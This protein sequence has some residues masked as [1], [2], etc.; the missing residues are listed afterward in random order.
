VTRDEITAVLQ[1]HFRPEFLNR[2][3]EIVTFHPLERE[4]LRL[5]VEIQ[6]QRVAELLAERG[7]DLDVTPE[8]VDYLTEV[9]YNPDFGARPLKR[10][11]QRELQ[12]PLALAILSGKFLEGELIRVERGQEGLEFSPVLNSAEMETPVV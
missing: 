10:A 2:I 8:A 1:A 11:I 7:F 3:D 12:D 5:I 4:H 9:G 6:L